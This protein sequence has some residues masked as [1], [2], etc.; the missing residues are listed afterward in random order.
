LWAVIRPLELLCEWPAEVKFFVH[1]DDDY[2]NND[3]ILQT[4]WSFESLYNSCSKE[5]W[6]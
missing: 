1:D 4:P 6:N 3:D 2:D 5:I